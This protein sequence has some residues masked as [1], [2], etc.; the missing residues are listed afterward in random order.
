MGVWR[1]NVCQR[2]R[3]L[4]QRASKKRDD[5]EAF[6]KAIIP[7]ALYA[8]AGCQGIPKTWTLER[9]GR[10]YWLFRTAGK[11]RKLTSKVRAFD[12]P[13]APTIPRG[14]WVVRGQW[15]LSTSL[16][17]RDKRQSYKIESGRFH[18]IPAANNHSRERSQVAS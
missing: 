4:V 7:E 18:F 16:D 10:P 1:R 12:H 15:Y 13:K 14:T 8:A 5:V 2:T 9:G 3:G 6:A 11:A 17:Y